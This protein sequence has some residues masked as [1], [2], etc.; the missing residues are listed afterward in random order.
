MDVE[1]S[2]GRS[3]HVDGD[4]WIDLG[5]PPSPDSSEDGA[6][7]APTR[8]C[9]RG[10]DD[11]HNNPFAVPGVSKAP[12]TPA[13][14]PLATPQPV[15]E[16]EPEQPALNT[17]RNHSK[18]KLPQAPISKPTSNV[19][20]PKKPSPNPPGPVAMSKAARSKE[21]LMAFYLGRAKQ[22]EAKHQ[23]MTVSAG[24]VTS[25]RSAPIGL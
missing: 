20:G 21:A 19:P 3:V 2:F 16:P 17:P 12:T 10:A 22:M 4:E 6:E 25:E 18:T 15:T 24:R 23:K 9:L 7:P 8:D 5:P 13:T 14:A 11:D 1:C